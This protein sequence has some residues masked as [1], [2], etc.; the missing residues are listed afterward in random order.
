MIEFRLLGP[1]ELWVG[2]TRLDVGQ[3]RQRAVLAVLAADA[4]RTVSADTLIDRL[5]GET[6]PATARRSLHAHVARVRGVLAQAG[7]QVALI[8]CTGGYRLDTEPE[9]VDLHRMRALLERGRHDVGPLREAVALWRGEPLTGVTGPWADRMRQSWQQEHLDLMLAWARAELVAGDPGPVIRRLSELTG[10]HPLTEPLDTE[11]IRALHTAGRSAEALARYAEVRDRLADELGVD[12]GTELQALHRT[13]LGGPPPAPVVPAQLPAEVA[14]FTGRD[15]LLAELD[16]LP[17]GAVATLSGPAGV[18]KTSLAVHWAR[19][20]AH[21]FPDGQLYADLRGFD[22]GDQVLDPGE[23]VR[24]FLHALGVPPDRMPPTAAAQAGLYRSLLAGRRVLVLLD[25]ARDADHVRDLLPGSPTGLTVVTS[26]NQ[27][28]PLLA[29]HGARPVRLVPLTAGEAHDLLSR[30]LGAGRVTA[31][32]GA[33]AQ[34]IDAC[35]GLPLA[36]AI[37]AARVQHNTFPLQAFAGEL[38]GA[39]LDALDAGDSATR[40]ET[41]FDWSYTALSPS[42][43]RLFRLL[44]LHPGPDVGTAAAAGLTGERPSATRRDLAELVRASMLAEQAPGRYAFHDLLRAYAGKGTRDEAATTR[45]LDHYLHTASAAAKILDP[46]QDPL[47]LEPPAPGVRVDP[48]VKY[49]EAMDWFTAERLPLL[50]VIRQA[51]AAGYDAVSWQLTLSMVTFLDWQGYW[52]DLEA[53]CRIA[54]EAAARCADATALARAHRNLSVAHL[55]LRRFDEG[56]AE[57]RTALGISTGAGDVIGQAYAHNSLAALHDR[58]DRPDLAL[59]EAR[60]S[61]ELFETT[62]HRVGQANA[63]N[64]VG[65]YQ[66]LLG[67]YEESVASCRRALALLEELGDRYGQAHTW[68]SLGY[69][70][71][72][73]GRHADAVDCYQHAVAIFHDL[74]DRYQEADTTGKLGDVHQGAGDLEAARAAWQHAWGI[75]TELDHPDAAALQARLG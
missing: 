73:L 1:V 30:R 8:H 15:A 2:D 38:A 75:L 7:G 68:D 69:S 29:T 24:G 17:P 72:H 58:Q 49:E 12:P 71:H 65:W 67:A 34:I 57:L 50:A 64:S 32:P 16:A 70:A 45:L 48:P 22:A 33:T 42:A 23:A 39:R 47:S 60:R 51:A 28:T 31:D 9:R 55:G 59:P 53:A 25:N 61:L 4:G 62:G 11:L 21:L 18:G 43:A 14:G 37:A 52:H 40:I 5:W 27:L 41:V 19:R 74:G 44:S 35:A 10:E 13:I 63:L 36:L 56:E 3:P 54:V 20:A 66:A 6:P 26:R 46:A